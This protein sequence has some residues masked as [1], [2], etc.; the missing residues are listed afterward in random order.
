MGSTMMAAIWPGWAA[1]AASTAC[2]VVVG[3]REGEAGDLLG[4]AGG[5]GNAEGGDAGA[6]FDEKAV[7]MA[8]IAAFEFDDDFAAGGGA[9]QAD[10]RHGGL[11]AGADEAHLLDGGVAGDDALGEVGF[12]GRGRSKAGG[13]ARGALDGFDDGRKGMAQ[14][15]RSPGAEVVD[16]AVAVGIGEPGALGGG[17]EGRCAADGAKGP[18]GRVDAAGEVALGAL[19]EGLGAGVCRCRGRGTHDGFSI[20][21]GSVAIRRK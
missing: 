15:H 4:D 11:G 18:H 13:V 9:G 2:E 20:E 19:L 7:R 8:V 17:D 12:R 3:Q 6:G 1:K 14:N 21:G 10:G 16:V 5:A